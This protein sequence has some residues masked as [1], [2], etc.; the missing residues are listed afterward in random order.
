M[1]IEIGHQRVVVF[2]GGTIATRRI[3][4]MLPFGCLIT[5]ITPV[6]SKELS[7]LIISGF[8]EW[9]NREYQKGDCKDAVIVL[10]CTNSRSVNQAIYEEACQTTNYYNIC[11]CKE[12]CSFYFPGIARKE[13]VVV[14]I[15][16]N[17][18]NHTLAR[19]ITKK[20][21]AFLEQE[22]EEGRG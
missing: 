6:V 11:D 5:V 16:A 18:G 8:I 9:I 15:T 13:Q 17:G 14:G 22:S 10:S 21:Q 20:M 4:A 1:F 7:E 12:Q 2:G 19:M 3:K